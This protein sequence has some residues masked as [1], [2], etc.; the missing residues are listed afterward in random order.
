MGSH[1][2]NTL[3]FGCLVALGSVRVR[4]RRIR[5]KVPVMGRV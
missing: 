3:R 2:P 4:D 5:D 1:R